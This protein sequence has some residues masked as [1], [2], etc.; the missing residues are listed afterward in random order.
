MELHNNLLSGELDE[1]IGIMTSLSYLD[2]HGNNFTDRIPSEIGKLEDLENLDLSDNSFDGTI[3]QE[4]MNLEK[5]G[6]INHHIF[7]TQYTN[8]SHHLFSVCKLHHKNI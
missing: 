4:I 8:L 7:Q 1:S 5:M 2:V 3:P 6:E